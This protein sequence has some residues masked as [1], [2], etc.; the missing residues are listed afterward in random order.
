MEVPRHFRHRPTYVPSWGPEAFVVPL[1]AEKIPA[2]IREFGA[3]RKPG[4]RVLDAGCGLQPFRGLLEQAGY[5]YASM[6]VVQNE[7]GTVGFVAALDEPLPE[8]LAGSAPYD[9]ILCTEVMEHVANWEAAF[10][11]VARLLGP[12]GRILFTCPHFYPLHE[13]PY[14][15]WRPTPFAFQFFAERHGLK[16]LHMEQA[17][18]PREVLG[19]VLAETY[20]YPAGGGLWDRVAAKAARVVRN[21]AFAALKSEKCMARIR[22][23][24]PYFLSVLAVA[25][26]EGRGSLN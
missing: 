17:G 18:G 20:A 23:K 15:F 3:P 5:R 25:E 13:T 24:G 22:L 2:L 26:K 4:A 10:A 19:T 1:L 16:L 8:P 12:G 6:D 7:P 14:D 11:N 9:F 21:L